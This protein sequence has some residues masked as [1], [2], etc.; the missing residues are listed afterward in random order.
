LGTSQKTIC[1][2]HIHNHSFSLWK[3][4]D[5]FT[6]QFRNNILPK[7]FIVCKLA[8]A[9]P[10]ATTEFTP[11]FKCGSCY[12]IFSFICMFCRLLFVLL[13]FFFWPLCCLF[14]FDIQILIT[15]LVSSN[16]SS[17]LNIIDIHELFT[18]R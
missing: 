4:T 8:F 1:I 16:S 17:F 5:Q 12:S 14:F 3:S 10:S 6:D 15:P 9:Y 13:Y 11:G 2:S 18:W 7:W